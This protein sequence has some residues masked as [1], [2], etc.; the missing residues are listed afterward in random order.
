MG[1]ESVPQLGRLAAHRSG[2]IV[3]RGITKGSGKKKKKEKTVG[4]GFL[5]TRP[6]L[7]RGRRVGPSMFFY[8]RKTQGGNEKKRGERKVGGAVGHGKRPSPVLP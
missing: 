8:Q 7:T 3:C 2:V 1:K 5:T 4:G 6:A